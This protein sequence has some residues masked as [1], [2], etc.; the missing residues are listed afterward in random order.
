M[1]TKIGFIFVGARDDRG[2]NQAAWEASEAV[3]RAFPDEFVLRR[4]NVPES[5]AATTAMEDLIEQGARLIFATSFG[6]LPYAV[7]VARKHPDVVVLHQGGREPEPRLNNLGTFWGAVYEPMYQAGIAAGDATETGR[8]GFVAAFP[9]PATF[10][11][12]NAFTL[13]AQSVRPGVKTY[14]EFTGSWCDPAKQR[15]SVARL[16]RQRVDVLTQ[17]QD[18]TSTVIEQA[19]TAGLA[20][21]GYHYDA[22]ELAPRAW[23]TGAVWDWKTLFIDI[24]QTVLDGGFGGSVYNLD[25]VGNLQN[26]DNPFVLTELNPRIGA[27]ARTLIARAETLFRAGG[28]PF[29]GPLKDRGG[30]VRVVA[31]TTP[32][33]AETLMM[34]YFVPGVIGDIPTG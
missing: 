22:S 4:E 24:V 31:D 3:S 27:R 15:S 32:S 28:S 1:G 11:N 25:F 26:G 12:V 10:N 17:H 19:Q 2:Y 21:V 30:K 13:G 8:L 5:E 23:L 9:I 6:H 20:T 16:L 34:D 18:C 29:D 33:Y 7:E 14:V